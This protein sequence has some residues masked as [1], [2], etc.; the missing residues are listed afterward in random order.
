VPSSGSS[1]EQAPELSRRTVGDLLGVYDARGRVLVPSL[2]AYLEGGRV[3]AALHER[4]G[5]EISRAG[6]LVNDVLL[7]TSCRE[8]GVRL[9]TENTNDF[10]TIQRHLRGFRFV[11][12]DE[13][14]R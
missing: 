4:E 3:L 10:A 1:C 13:A 14:L 12:A 11:N 6:S 5:I 8:A 7:A 9:V 2:G